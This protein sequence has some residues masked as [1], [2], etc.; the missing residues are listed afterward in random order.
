MSFTFLRLPRILLKRGKG[1]TSL[2]EE[3]R[4]GLFPH[5]VWI[6][7]NSKAWPDFEV[8]QVNAALLA[9]KSPDEIRQ[10]VRDLEAARKTVLGQRA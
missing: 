2:Y 7:P 9:G 4:A 5:G 10:L 3:I 8:D 6:G 1:R